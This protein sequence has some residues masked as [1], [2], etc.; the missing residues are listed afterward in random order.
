MP[1]DLLH[2]TT[3]LGVD[4]ERDTVELLESVLRAAGAV[5]C[6]A[7][8]ARDALAL[9]LDRAAAA[10]VS[11]IG[12]PETDGCELMRRILDALGPAAPR[13]RIA[14]T[15]YA[16]ERDRARTA[17]AGF[18]HHLAKPLDPLALVAGVAHALAASPCSRP[19]GAGQPSS[20]SSRIGTPS[21]SATRARCRTDGLRIP[22]SMPHM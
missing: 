11:D 15:A 13:A 17:A 7:A 3:G 5:A 21:A 19:R 18:Q 2:G 16:G 8:I 9:A 12:M 20:K 10:I 14:L 22:C 6:A 4:D 1:P